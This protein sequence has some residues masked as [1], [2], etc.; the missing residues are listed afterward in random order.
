M[1]LA[2]I[3]GL[4]STVYGCYWFI[5]PGL[6]HFCGASAMDTVSVTQP[7]RGCELTAWS[8]SCDTLIMGVKSKG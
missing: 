2:S 7:D 6:V 3:K 5:H 4:Q 8:D 1:Q